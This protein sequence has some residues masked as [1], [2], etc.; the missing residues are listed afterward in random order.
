MS[1]KKC[2][3]SVALDG[4]EDHM[5]QQESDT[6]D[7]NQSFDGFGENDITIGEQASIID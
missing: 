7:D 2:G 1:F 4:T 6:D 3:I 5:F